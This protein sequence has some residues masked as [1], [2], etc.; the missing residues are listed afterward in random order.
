M[1]A[2]RIIFGVVVAAHGLIHLM[3][4]IKAFE[5]AEIKDIKLEISKPVGLV[6]LAA[7]LGFLAAVALLLLQMD[8]W[9]WVAAP[10]AVLSQVLVVAA[11][12]EAKFGTIANLIVAAGVVYLLVGCQSTAPAQ[13]KPQQTQTSQPAPC[14][15][16]ILEG[17]A[18]NARDLGGVALTPGKVACGQ[19]YRGGDLGR[20]TD[21]GCAELGRLGIKTVVDLRPRPAGLPPC[22]SGSTHV[23][24]AP[25]PKPRGSPEDHYRAMLEA[26]DS[27]KKLFAVLGQEASYPVYLECQVGGQLVSYASALVLLALGAERRAV[28]EEFR[29]SARAG[30]DLPEAGLVAAMDEIDQQ[31]GIEAFL[32]SAGVGKEDLAVLSAQLISTAP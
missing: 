6:W 1:L 29:R 20:I 2:I 26:K 5:L 15:D 31:G 7:A 3:G 32:R 23:V 8:W 13:E 12:K 24:S 18:T 30:R 9:W 14:R 28:L 11:W 21:K 4:F 22:L 16:K 17:E 10:S 19:L 25:L 27:A